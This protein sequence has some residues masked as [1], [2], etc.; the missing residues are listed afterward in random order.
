MARFYN[1]PVNLAGLSTASSQPDA[2]YGHEATRACLLAYLAGADEIY[3]VGLLGS[4]QVLSLEKMVLDNHLIHQIEAT[5]EPVLVDDARLQADLIEQVGVGGNYLSQRATREFTR[6]EYRSPW[7]AAGETMLHTARKEALA[8]LSEH[9][10]PELPPAAQAK[11]E[12]LVA[13]ASRELP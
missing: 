3:S 7:P 11:L 1:L 12:D 9:R 5:L 4:A 10:P 2:Q 8:I 13:D 6:R